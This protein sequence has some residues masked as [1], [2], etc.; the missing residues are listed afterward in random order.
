[1]SDSLL[2]IIVVELL[3]ILAILIAIA[4]IARSIGVKLDQ[5]PHTPFVKKPGGHHGFEVMLPPWFSIWC[6]T[7]GEWSL[8]SPC[9][10][11][12]CDCGPP[13]SR[14]GTYEEQ[15]IRKECPKR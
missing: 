3:A 10:Q 7:N 13:P 1:M 5:M 2:L 11:P 12:G 14:P 6:W 15:V 4:F 8:M 9:G